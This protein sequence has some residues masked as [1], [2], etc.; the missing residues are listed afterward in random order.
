MTGD[1]ITSSFGEAIT[2]RGDYATV[3]R[4]YERADKRCVVF[5]LTSH[6]ARRLWQEIA[7]APR[8]DVGDETTL[9]AGYHELMDYG[10]ME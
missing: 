10:W 1:A 2:L 7:Y 5:D 9:R 8:V 4:Q 6:G 3:R